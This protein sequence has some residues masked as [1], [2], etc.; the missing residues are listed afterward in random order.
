MMEL[1]QGGKNPVALPSGET[2]TFLQDGD[3][4]IERGRCDANGYRRIGFG[5][6]AARI[7]G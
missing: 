6:A 7:A 1:T 2:R 4:V 5:E 3:E